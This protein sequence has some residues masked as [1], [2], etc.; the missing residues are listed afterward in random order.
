MNE[1][2]VIFPGSWRGPEEGDRGQCLHE[3][4]FSQFLG[5][6]GER[7][8]VPARLKSGNAYMNGFSVSFASNGGPR[9]GHAGRSEGQMQS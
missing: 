3:Q 7:A 8:S 1:P 2:S 5:A 9:T 6:D 4:A